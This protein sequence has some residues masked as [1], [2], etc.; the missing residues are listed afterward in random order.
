MYAAQVGQSRVLAIE[1]EAQNFAIL[2][3]NIVL[4]NLQHAIVATNLAMSAKFGLGRLSVHAITKG[5]AYYSF[6]PDGA[7]SGSGV[8]TQVQVGASLDDL[9]NRFGFDVPTHIKIDVDGHEPDIIRGA[10]EV[11]SNERCRSIL[12]EIQR[13][14][15]DHLAAV[16]K[17]QELGYKCV[18]QR[19]TWASRASR[20]LRGTEREHPTV[21]MIFARA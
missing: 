17:L 9:V 6:V 14:D 21:N 10:T 1:P 15:P 11:L 7:E 20:E 5:G 18:L 8:M 12:I 13:N 19:S 3:E 2:I 16:G 4:N